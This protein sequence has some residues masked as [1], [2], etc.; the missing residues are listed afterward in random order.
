M[1]LRR[2]D[3]HWILASNAGCDEKTFIKWSWFYV[4]AIANLDKI[5]VRKLDIIWLVSWSLWLGSNIIITCSHSS[6]LFHT[7]AI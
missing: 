6:F 5:L 3:T 2:Y 1:F 7:H 4:E